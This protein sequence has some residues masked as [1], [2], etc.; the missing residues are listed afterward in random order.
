MSDETI[1]TETPETAAEEPQPAAQQPGNAPGS[2]KRNRAVL[3]LLILMIIGGW[4]GLKWFIRSQTHLET[5]NAFIEARIVPVSSRVSGTV[6]RVPAGDNQHVRKGDLL[7]EIDPRDYQLQ[8]AQASAGI[9][10]AL[11]TRPAGNSRRRPAPGRRCSL[12]GPD[13]IRPLPI[14]GGVKICSVVRSFRRNS[15]SV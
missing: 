15:S 4:I 5:D 8:V 10:L 13:M 12:P 1:Q 2:G 9:G 11:K 7:L 14:S 3:I 6:L